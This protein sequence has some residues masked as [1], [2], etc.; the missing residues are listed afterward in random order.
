MSFGQQAMSRSDVVISRLERLTAG[1][2]SPEF[3]ALC[4]SVLE[5]CD[6]MLLP[7]ASVSEGL[8]PRDDLSWAWS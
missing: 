5:A 6:E 2:S 3:S 4:L 7:S 1:M 8:E